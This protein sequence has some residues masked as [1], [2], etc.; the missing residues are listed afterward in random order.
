MHFGAAAKA[1]LHKPPLECARSQGGSALYDIFV[2]FGENSLLV[3]CP[4]VQRQPDG[5][6]VR[7]EKWLLG[8]GFL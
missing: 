5:L 1:P 6:T 3:K 2:I 8:A 4:S 7:A